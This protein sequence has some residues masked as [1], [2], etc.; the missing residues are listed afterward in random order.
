[1]LLEIRNDCML[2]LAA[3]SLFCIF[4]VVVGIATG[5]LPGLHVN[6]VALILITLSGGIYSF[7][8]AIF[9][10]HLS[11][12]FIFILISGFI[13]SVSISHTFHNIIPATF[14]GAPEEDTALSVL[15]THR[16]L[17]KGKGY[18]AVALSTL[19]SFGAI[20]V[21]LSLIYGMR[22][23]L[24]SPLFLYST[25]QEIMVWVLIAISIFMVT[26]EKAEISKIG[27]T[28]IP[29]P[30]TGVLFATFVFF[31]SGIFGLVVLD[32]KL[33]SPIPGLQAPVLFPALT[34]LFG[35]PTLIHSLVTKPVIPCQKIERT[36]VDNRPST[37]LSIVTGSLAGVFV[38]I[39]PG[40]TSAIGTIIAINA[41][42][43]TG[44]E[45]TIITLSS[46]NTAS[47]FSV[48]VMLFI[49][50]RSRSGVALAVNDL[51]TVEKWSS[52]TMPTNLSYLLIFLLLSGFLSYF[53]ALKIGEVFAKN[54]NKIPYFLVVK[55][56]IAMITILVSLFTGILGILILISA[57]FIGYL[58]ILWGVRRSHCMGLLLIPIIL[59]LL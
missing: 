47:A 3:I 49:I 31:L 6:N 19:G 8:T 57:T 44:D 26:T 11:S 20:M 21:C 43:R 34:G 48:I 9:D 35:I 29:P 17:L 25:L 58:P 59:H 50:L 24:G 14:L 22:F 4:G 56:I 10:L 51:I 28:A 33:E 45:Q 52:I 38:S 42:E 27:I 2:D 37:I 18:E 30:I 1:M 15:P 7:C 39:I 23:L 40:I 5:I 41:R 53:S 46:V 54:F 12:G 16:F 36:S 32:F 55:I 13:V